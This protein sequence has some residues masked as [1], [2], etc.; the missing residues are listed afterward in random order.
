MTDHDDPP[1]AP[2]QAADDTTPPAPAR[3]SRGRQVVAA[4]VTLAVL[5]IVFLGIFP[6]FASYKDAWAS[7]QEM[8]TES[9]VLLAVATV[10]NILVYVLPYQAA[11]PGLAY[12]PAFV[13]RQTS[14]MI[15]NTIPLG[16]AFGLGVQYAMLS[17]YGFGPAPT[18][19]AIGI[20]SVWNLFVTLGLPVLALLGL[21]VSGEATGHSVWITA[22]GLVGI[23]VM[24]ALFALV[25]RSEET[26][27]K[28][29]KLGNRI[30]HRSVR[31]VHRDVEPH[32]D[33]EIVRFRTSTVDV[34]RA[35]WLRI[36]LTSVL[37]QL[38]QFAV[39]YVALVGLDTSGSGGTVS[40]AEAFSAFAFS[41]LASFIPVTPG[42]LGTVDAALVALLTAAGAPKDVALAADM[43]WR[44]CT[45]FPQVFLGI[46][47]FVFWRQQQSR[48]KRAEAAQTT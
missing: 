22:L 38:A 43:V 2:S 25:L 14:F 23:G 5:V 3:P 17:G 9:L 32:L 19:A 44:A 13:V 8:S 39:L 41:R 1:P 15:S 29:G 40:L 11:L 36:S 33:D 7:I 12:G 42:G 45:L 37:Q 24:V 28:I 18:T 26:A 20:T 27:R 10:V 30:V 46:G 48:E 6:K 4:L 47:T 34:I 16:G 31:L 21:A 35:R